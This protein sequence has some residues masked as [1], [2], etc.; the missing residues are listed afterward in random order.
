MPKPRNPLQEPGE[1]VEGARLFVPESEESKLVEVSRL[2]GIG[3][4]TGTG[5]C[6]WS[7]ETMLSSVDRIKS[8]IPTSYGCCPKGY[9]LDPPYSGGI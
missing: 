7:V 9:G 4:S 6:L 5:A 2:D 1:P 3:V 8:M